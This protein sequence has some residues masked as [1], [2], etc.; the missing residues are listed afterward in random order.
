MDY[1]PHA[2]FETIGTGFEGSL[3]VIR[4]NVS[5]D[6]LE[7]YDTL[8]KDRE[9]LDALDAPISQ[10]PTTRTARDLLSSFCPW[11][12]GVYFWLQG[13]GLTDQLDFRVLRPYARGLDKDLHENFKVR[14]SWAEW[15]AGTADLVSPQHALGWGDK[16]FVRFCDYAPTFWDEEAGYQKQVPFE[17]EDRLRM[18]VNLRPSQVPADGVYT[19]KAG[20]GASGRKTSSGFEGGEPLFKAVSADA[21]GFCRP[22]DLDCAELYFEIGGSRPV[23]LHYRQVRVGEPYIS[24]VPAYRH[25]DDFDTPPKACSRRSGRRPRLPASGARRGRSAASS[26]GPA[27][28]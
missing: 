13:A 24:S 4:R 2:G 26:L 9:V 3:G 7:G 1:L 22:G 8:E 14:R 19:F 18:T 28:A 16:E 20:V 27:P 12:V 5:H 11:G 6:P 23:V 17:L 10:I 21:D 15:Y 25:P